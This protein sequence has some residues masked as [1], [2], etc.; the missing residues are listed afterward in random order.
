M[1]A[2]DYNGEVEIPCTT[3]D[4][5]W[6]YGSFS[7]VEGFNTEGQFTGEQW[8]EKAPVTRLD[9]Y[10][11][12]AALQ[13]LRLLKIDVEGMEV[14]VLDGAEELIKRHR[15]CLFVENNNART[16]DLLIQK[17]ESLNYDSYWFCSERFSPQNFNGETRKVE[18]GD[19]NMVCFPAESRADPGPLIRVKE[20]ADLANGRVSYL[21]FD[22][23]D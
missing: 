14:A 11:R 6:N 21:T 18:G 5:P 22:E 19:Y 10:P 9:D 2:A 4:T 16:G 7:I 20:F 8:M 3:Y 17:I 13:S 1:A 12:A 23:P 15:P